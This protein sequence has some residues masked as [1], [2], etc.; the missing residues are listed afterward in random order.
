[1]V[2]PAVCA[3]W[4]PQGVPQIHTHS[5]HHPRAAPLPTALLEEAALPSPSSPAPPVADPCAASGVSWARPLGR[6]CGR[7]GQ[8]SDLQSALPPRPAQGRGGLGEEG[9]AEGARGGR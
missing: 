7:G 9:R 4:L 1:M 8:G 5:P 6:C 3:S 2:P